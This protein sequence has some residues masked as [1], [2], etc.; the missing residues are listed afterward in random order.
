M[1]TSFKRSHA[2]SAALNA[3]NPAAGHC[4]P[5]PC[6]RLLDTLGKPGLV[7]C[8]GSAPFSWVL[9]STRFC[10]CLPK[11]VSPSLCKFW[12]LYGGVNGDLLQ[13]GLCH[14]PACCTQ[15]PCHCSRPLLPHTFAGDT[16]HSKADL[17]QSLWGLLVVH[18][19]LFE[20]SKHL[21]WLQG[22]ILNVISPLLSFCLSL[23]FALDVGSFFG[24]IQQSPV[25][26][27]SAMSCNPKQRKQLFRVQQTFLTFPFSRFLCFCYTL[28]FTYTWCSSPHV[29][30]A[31]G[32]PILYIFFKDPAFSFLDLCYVFF[33]FLLFLL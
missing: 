11:S 10:L 17:A 28:C 1:V 18:E 13:E 32:L 2:R 4:Q 31:K 9:V 6:Q 22:F 21:W 27:C 25:D 7:S 3:P 8:G 33:P 12:Q 14:P 26:G 15:S 16:Q 30:L 24:G 5:T 19:F 23:S 29:S 20:P